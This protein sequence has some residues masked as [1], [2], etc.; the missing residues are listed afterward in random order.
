MNCETCRA[1]GSGIC[2]ECWRKRERER[3]LKWQA[4]SDH[5]TALFN[6]FVRKEISADECME[7]LHPEGDR[8]QVQQLIERVLAKW[9]QQESKQPRAATSKRKRDAFGDPEK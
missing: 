7:R 3:E 9:R 2:P 5:D 4:V 8:R 1:Q 6:A